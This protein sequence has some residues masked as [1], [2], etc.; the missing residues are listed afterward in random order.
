MIVLAVVIAYTRVDPIQLTTVTMAA[1]AVA[2]PFTFLPLLI[3]ANDRE[4]VGEQR[5]RAALNL[6]AIL[7]LALLCLVTLAAIPLF[8]LSGGGG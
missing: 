7:I 6:V 8:V 4:Y 3:V 2:L 1:A 5:N